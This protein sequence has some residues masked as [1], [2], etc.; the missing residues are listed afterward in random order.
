MYEALVSDGLDKQKC[1]GN[2]GCGGRI[3][4]LTEV[5][6]SPLGISY[7]SFSLFWR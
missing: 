5:R 6:V 2:L 7:L 3:S 1:S 4:G